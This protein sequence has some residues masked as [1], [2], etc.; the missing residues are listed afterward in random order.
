M[1]HLNYYNYLSLNLQ[2]APV[3]IQMTPKQY[4]QKT[5]ASHI[6]CGQGVNSTCFYIP[7]YLFIPVLEGRR[8]KTNQL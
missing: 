1:L 7:L 2:I 3:L 8:S 4:W 5:F 6:N